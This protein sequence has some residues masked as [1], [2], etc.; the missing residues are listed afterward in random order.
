VENKFLP[1]AQAGKIMNIWLLRITS[2]QFKEDS[3]IYSWYIA[4]KG[5][6]IY[7]PPL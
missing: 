3:R 2:Y 4:L 1:A 6:A 7:S 5:K